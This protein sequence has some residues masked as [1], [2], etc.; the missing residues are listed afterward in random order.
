[1]DLKHKKILV[2]GKGKTGKSTGAFLKEKGAHVIIRDEN[3]HGPFLTLNPRDYDLVY[4]S[5]GISRQHPFLLK[6]DAEGIPISNEIELAYGFTDSPMIGVTGTNGKTTIST[7]IH[8]ILINCGVKAALAGNVGQPLIDLVAGDHEVFVVELSSYQLEGIDQ[9]A[10]H[11]AILSNLTPDHLERHKTMEKYLEIKTRIYKRMKQ[12]DY[13]LLNFDDPWLKKLEPKGPTVYFFSSTEKVRGIFRRENRIILNLTEEIDLC[14]VHDLK[15]LGGHNV[16][17]AMA[18]LLACFL[19]GIAIECILDHTKSFPGVLH[20]LEYVRTLADV[21]YFNDS[22]A[23]N[24]EAAIIALQSFP[25]VKINAIFGGSPKKVE[26]LSL[27]SMIKEKEALAILQGQ[28]AIEIK[29]ALQQVEYSNFIEVENL[30][31]AVDVAHKLARPGEVVVLTPACASFDQ[32]V[33]FEQRGER[34]K[35]YVNAIKE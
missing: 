32:F 33:N 11:I 27:A 29:E 31:E 12:N 7:L 9:F 22:K 20:R 18:A 10:P 13:L 30:K 26:Y 28:T 24:P 4:Q 3:E 2:L 35:E 19:Y 17:N 5:P 6:C 14:S 25:G 16:E 21:S 34:F 1:M 23:T 8:Y 15:I